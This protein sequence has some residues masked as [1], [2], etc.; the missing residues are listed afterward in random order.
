MLPPGFRSPAVIQSARWLADPIGLLDD[1]RRRFGDMFTLRVLRLGTVVAVSDPDVIRQIFTGDPEVFHAGEGRPFLR[2]LVGE[3]SI[4][5]LDGATHM[6]K[7]R[8]LLPPFHGER[9]HAYAETIRDATNASIDTW[10]IGHVF[11]LQPALQ[12]ITLQVIVRAVFGVRGDAESRLL[13]SRLTRLVDVA[14]SPL[15]F[16][17]AILGINSFEAAPRLPASRLKAEVDRLVFD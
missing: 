11:P 16:I 7:R 4:L 10:P 6:R 9:M 15:R 1:G 17:P 3:T 14:S 12:R 8:L 13:S 5:V 2:P